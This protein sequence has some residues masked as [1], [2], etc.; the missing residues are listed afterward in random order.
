MNVHK[1]ARMTPQG[2]L[3]LVRRVREQGWRVGDAAAL[4]GLSR[5]TA[6]TVAGALSG[7]RRARPSI[8]R[9][10]APARSPRRLPADV[11]RRD[12]APAPAA[13]ERA[14]RSR[15]SWPCR[16]RP[17]AASCAGS[18]SAGWP[19]SSR[20][21]R[22]CATSARGRAS[23]STSTPRSSAGS[24]A[25]AIASPA[26]GATATRGA[27][28]EALHVAHRRRLAPGLQRDPAR[29]AQGQRRRLPRPRA[30]LVRAPRR[31]R[32]AGH[33]RQ[34]LGLPQPRLPPRLRRAGLRHLRTR[35]YTPRTNGKAERFI[36]T[37]LR[38]W[39][40]ARPFATSQERAAALP[41][42]LHHY[43][44]IGRMPPSPAD[45]PSP[46]C[47]EQPPW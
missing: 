9:S 31:H 4:P 24:T 2:R 29:R 6:R 8:D 22:S 37:G 1:N 34:R 23:C 25:S 44:A 13:P 39:A 45:H 46:A 41:R 30:R 38:E 33:D 20:G 18:G 11:R 5:A 36:Q 10:S 42:W 3:L 26:T 27:G 7:G 32:R 35:P 21:R 16:S 19:R 15:A 47:H 12:R 43:N 14:G 28:W 40:Y 17:S